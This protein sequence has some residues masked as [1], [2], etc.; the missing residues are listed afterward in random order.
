ML[1]VLGEQETQLKIFEKPQVAFDSE[2]GRRHPLTILLAE[3]NVTNQKVALHFLKRLGYQADV[4]L[5]GIEAYQAGSEKDYD[6][7][8]MDIQMPEMDGEEATI[9]IRKEI[10]PEKQP[11]IIALTAHALES[12]RE[13]YLLMGM[14][15]FVAKPFTLQNLIAA[16]EKVP[17]HKVVG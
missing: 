7:V 15:D 2:M 10:A 8:L 13:R 14:N 3:D 12:Y 16:L 4:A 5:N 11:Y 17:Q 1:M 9:K 6:V